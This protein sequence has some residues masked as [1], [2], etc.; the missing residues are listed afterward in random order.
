MSS[1]ETT[2]DHDVI[3]AWAEKRGGRPSLVRTGGRKGG[4]KGGGVLRLD[5]GPKEEKLEETSWE[6]F[7][8]VFDQ[9]GLAFLFQDKT[10]DGKE[11]RFSRFVKQETA[12]AKGGSTV[13]APSR[14]KAGGD[15]GPSKAE[16]MEKARTQNVPGRSKMSKAELEKALA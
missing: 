16:L 4:K 1:S 3:R 13:K 14:R 11:S 7:F 12:A 6:E 8:E 15:G 10:K 5:F 2:T 9:S